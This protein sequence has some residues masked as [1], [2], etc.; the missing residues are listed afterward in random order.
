MKKSGMK[1]RDVPVYRTRLLPTGD[2]RGSFILAESVIPATRD[3]LVSFAVA[4]IHDG[5]HEGMAF[6]AGLENSEFKSTVILGVIVPDADHSSQRVMASADAVGNAARV[7][8]AHG[9]G[10]LCQAHSHPG[11][12]TRHSDGD[13]DLVLLPFEGML[14][15]VVPEFGI[16]F[17]SLNQASVHQFQDGRWVLCSAAS[18]AANIVV[19]PTRIDLRA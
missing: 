5:G 17:E 11:R 16:H 3:A 7:A 19:A 6:W 8:R 12:D 13:D 15:I 1:R 9:L 4:G 14:S 2:L 10:I 18:V